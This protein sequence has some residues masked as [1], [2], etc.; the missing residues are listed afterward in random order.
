[1]LYYLNDFFAILAP[2]DNAVLYSQHFDHIY[3]N[4]GV[5]INYIKDVIGIIVD[6]LGIEFNSILI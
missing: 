5:I 1:M 4:L 3:S 2:G 6:F